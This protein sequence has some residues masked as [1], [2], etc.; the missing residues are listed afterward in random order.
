M[1]IGE[2]RPTFTDLLWER[3]AP[4]GSAGSMGGGQPPEYLREQMR[5]VKRWED[6]FKRTKQILVNSSGQEIHEGDSFLISDPLDL[7]FLR[8]LFSFHE[9]KHLPMDKEYK[10]FIGKMH[11]IPTYFVSSHGEMCN[12]ESAISI[13]KCVLGL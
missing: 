3:S 7:L 13:R 9:S 10:V 5:E 12:E 2:H 1:M 8:T 6:I 4:M 11:N